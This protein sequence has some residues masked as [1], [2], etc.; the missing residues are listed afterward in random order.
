M[1]SATIKSRKWK[2]E[3][4]EKPLLH[5]LFILNIMKV[6]TPTS[7]HAYHKGIQPEKHGGKVSMKL[8]PRSFVFSHVQPQA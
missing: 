3:G 2:S 8:E 6:V 4:K 7:K 5:S 1:G